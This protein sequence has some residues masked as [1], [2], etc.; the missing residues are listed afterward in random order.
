M[1]KKRIENIKRKKKIVKTH[2][3]KKLLWRLVFFC[4]IVFV[5]LCIVAYD[6]VLGKI[7]AG[8]A[9]IGMIAGLGIGWVAGRM[10]K[11]YWCSEANKVVYQLDTIGI[12]ILI[13]YVTI[14]VGKQWVFRQ[15]FEGDQLFA[16]SLIFLS[17]LLVGRMLS[18]V[19]KIKKVLISERESWVIE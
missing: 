1:V 7:G 4:V 17:G 14:E 2:V 15:W 11:M 19:R 10:F 8:L 9:L 16:F 3:D 6:I 13:F 5:M 18:M 12:I